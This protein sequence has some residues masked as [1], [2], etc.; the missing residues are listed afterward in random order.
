MTSFLVYTDDQ[1]I[2]REIRL[3]EPPFLISRLDMPMTEI[4]KKDDAEKIKEMLAQRS[5]TNIDDLPAYQLKGEDL[6]LRLHIMTAGKR[7]MVFGIDDESF[8]QIKENT[9]TKKL[10]RDLLSAF[11][12]SSADIQMLDKEMVQ[13]NFEQIQLLNS[14]L[15]NTER[16]LQKERSKLELLNRELNN[17]LV[18]DA[19][20][21]LVSR[22]QYRAEIEHSIA[23]SPDSKGVFVF[24]DIDD[25]KRVN[26]SYGHT[27]GDEYLVEF[28]GRLESI[29][30]EN[31]VKMRISGDE[32]GLYLHGH[33]N[34]DPVF[35]KKIWLSIKKHV[36]YGP[37]VTGSDEIPLAV[38]AGMSV[39]GKDTKE[40]YDLIEYADFA[41]YQAKRSGK[42]QYSVFDAAEYQKSK[43]NLHF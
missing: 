10:L 37:I 13:M 15:M 35:M 34:P 8:Q 31:S 40:I 19:L 29:P 36:L 11:N 32:F 33:E 28:A 41:M 16:A 20:T 6:S 42:N 2:V 21:G 38:S 23:S 24:I 27:V 26:D 14:K 17:R 43:L 7:K 12:S 25:F 22:Y 30:I 18:K 3:S 39:Y 1:G 4:F 9:V 5:G